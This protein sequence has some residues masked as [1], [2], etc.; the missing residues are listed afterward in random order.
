[1]STIAWI[2]LGWFA[3]AVFVVVFWSQMKRQEQEVLRK[4]LYA[5]KKVWKGKEESNMSRSNH[6]RVI[7]WCLAF[8]VL[9]IVMFLILGGCYAHREYSPIRLHG[10][11]SIVYADLGD[12]IVVSEGYVQLAYNRWRRY[13]SKLSAQ[14]RLVRLSISTNTDGTWTIRK[15]VFWE[16]K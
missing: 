3:L 11:L 6:L 8:V 7:G 14:E 4:V 13:L 12:T 2:V 10:G 9:L 15:S 1:M 5:E 16:E